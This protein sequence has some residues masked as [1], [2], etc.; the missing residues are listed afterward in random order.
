MESRA[1]AVRRGL[2]LLLRS[3][4][5]SAVDGAFRDGY[6]RTPETDEE[7]AEAHRLGLASIEEEPWERWW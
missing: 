1:D 3:A 2:G 5:R 6:T 4:E 7:V